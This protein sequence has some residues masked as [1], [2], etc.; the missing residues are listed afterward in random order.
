MNCKS[1]NPFSKT[2]RSAFQREHFGTIRFLTS[3]FYPL[4][5]CVVT[6]THPWAATKTLERDAFERNC[7]NAQKKENFRQQQIQERRQQFKGYLNDFG[8]TNAIAWEELVKKETPVEPAQE[9]EQTSKRCP[10]CNK[11]FESKFKDKIYCSRSC[12]VVYRKKHNV[13]T[14][15]CINPNCGKEFESAGNKTCSKEC[16]AFLRAQGCRAKHQVRSVPYQAQ[17]CSNPDCGKEFKAVRKQPYCSRSCAQAAQVDAKTVMQKDLLLKLHSFG[18]IN[19]HLARL[20]NVDPTNVGA[21]LKRLGL[22]KNSMN[23]ECELRLWNAIAS[24]DIRVIEQ[25]PRNESAFGRKVP[26][27]PGDIFYNPAGVGFV[28]IRPFEPQF[29]RSLDPSWDGK[30][31]RLVPQRDGLERCK[32]LY[33]C[34]VARLLTLPNYQTH[35]IC[36]WAKHDKKPST[37]SLPRS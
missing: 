10:N 24:L 16:A 5:S 17:T 15:R 11:E 26:A 3:Q 35:V 1:G 18:L 36:R 32:D 4:H 2:D 13:K 37:I 19:T 22:E 30:G 27:F 28:A 25:L 20:L 23:G 12:S 6:A 33:P 8:H 14:R 9:P 34:W 21:W 7:P 31:E 29:D